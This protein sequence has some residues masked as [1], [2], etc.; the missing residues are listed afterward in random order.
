MR[1]CGFHPISYQGVENIECPEDEERK[2]EDGAERV[3]G[4]FQNNLMFGLL[5]IFE[6][7][8]T[9]LGV[10]VVVKVFI[11]SVHRLMPTLDQIYDHT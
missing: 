5:I 9:V 3:K 7:V 2:E 4:S 6:I 1:G 11:F 8:V 10:V